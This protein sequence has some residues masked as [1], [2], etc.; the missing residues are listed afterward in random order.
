L[1]SRLLIRVG[2]GSAAYPTPL[3]LLTRAD[4][5]PFGLRERCLWNRDRQNAGVE[6]L[7][8]VLV[9]ALGKREGAHERSIGALDHV[10]SAVLTFLS[11]APFLASDGEYAV[12]H[13]DLDI[14]GLQPG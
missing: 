2:E 4:L 3:L 13:R 1:A 7:D 5:N 14:L 9:Y 8:L 6:L 12:L 10:I 11:L